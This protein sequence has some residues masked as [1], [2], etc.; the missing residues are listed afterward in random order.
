MSVINSIYLQNNLD[1]NS[2]DITI[3]ESSLDNNGKLDISINTINTRRSIR[4]DNKN[5][6]YFKKNQLFDSTEDTKTR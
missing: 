1:I 5:V 6:C 4:N 3:N 2:S